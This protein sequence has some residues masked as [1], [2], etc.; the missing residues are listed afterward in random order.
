MVASSLGMCPFTLLISKLML[1]DSDS[2]FWLF[3]L[4]FVF[5]GSLHIQL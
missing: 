2:G 5:L 3:Y 4:R 1:N